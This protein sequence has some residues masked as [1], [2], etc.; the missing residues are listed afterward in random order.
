[1]NNKKINISAHL[2]NCAFHSLTP[3]ILKLLRTASNERSGFKFNEFQPNT[4]EAKRFK[5]TS[6]YQHFKKAFSEYFKLSKTDDVESKMQWLLGS[7]SHPLDVQVLLGPVLR[8]TLKSVLLESIA[9]RSM[10]KD[11]FWDLIQQCKERFENG[12]PESQRKNPMQIKQ[13]LINLDLGEENEFDE[14]Y[15]PNLDIITQ[16]LLSNRGAN[17]SNTLD[18]YGDKAYEQY[19]SH[20]CDVNKC[21]FVSKEQL[22]MLCHSFYF[23]LKVEGYQRFS[24]AS[25]LGFKP[26]ANVQLSNET[27]KHWEIVSKKDSEW[28]YEKTS[29][30]LPA[31][32][33][34]YHGQ[35]QHLLSSGATYRQVEIL[36]NTLRSEIHQSIADYKVFDQSVYTVLPSENWSNSGG[37]EDL[38]GLIKASM[39]GERPLPTAHKGGVETTFQSTQGFKDFLEHFRRYYS[40]EESLSHKQ[41]LEKAKWLLQSYPHPQEQFMI[42]TPVL[43]SLL[44]PTNLTPTA[45]DVQDTMRLCDIFNLELN[46]Y[47]S[48][49]DN[50]KISCFHKVFSHKTQ[51]VVF[52]TINIACVGQSFSPVR[53]NAIDGFKETAIYLGSKKHAFM[54]SANPER[55]LKDRLRTLQESLRTTCRT[56]MLHVESNTD[57]LAQI[58]APKTH[59]AEPIKKGATPVST[60]EA[61]LKGNDTQRLLEFIERHNINVNQPIPERQRCLDGWLKGEEGINWSPLHVAIYHGR[62]DNVKALIGLGADCRAKAQ[63]RFTS[64]RSKNAKLHNLSPLELAAYANRRDISALI[65]DS[66]KPGENDALVQSA[67]NGACAFGYADV[68][69]VFLQYPGI[70]HSTK[71]LEN[72]LS[73]Q[74]LFLFSTLLELG[75]PLPNKYQNSDNVLSESFDVIK[76]NASNNAIK[77]GIALHDLLM[78]TQHL[79]SKNNSNEITS[80][81][82]LTQK[83]SQLIDVAVKKG[84]SKWVKDIAQYQGEVGS[85]L[86][87]G[88]ASNKI[89]NENFEIILEVLAKN[90]CLAITNKDSNLLKHCLISE[91]RCLIFPGKLNPMHHALQKEKY[92]FLHDSYTQ[93]R[94]NHTVMEK[95]K[96]KEEIEARLKSLNEKSYDEY[97]R[98]FSFR[99][100]RS[101]Y[102]KEL[103]KKLAK[104]RWHQKPRLYGQ[105]AGFTLNEGRISIVDS[106]HLKGKHNA[107]V[108]NNPILKYG[109]PALQI[110]P[111]VGM[112]AAEGPMRFGME[113]SK[114]AAYRYLP[115][116]VE[117]ATAS[118]T[119]KQI[120]TAGTILSHGL[121]FALMPQYY[122]LSTIAGAGVYYGCKYSG[123]DRF[124]SL[125]A[126]TQLCADQVCYRYSLG[127]STEAV[128][129]DRYFMRLDRNLSA[130]FGAEA[131]QWLSPAV[132]GLDYANAQLNQIAAK[133]FEVLKPYF[134]ASTLET[135]QETLNLPEFKFDDL[136]F[137]EELKTTPEY[138]QTAQGYVKSLYQKRQMWE[139]WAFNYL[140][141]SI[142]EQMVDSTFKAERMHAIQAYRTNILAFDI[143]NTENSVK[144]INIKIEEASENLAQETAKLDKLKNDLES[145]GYSTEQ[146]L[147]IQ[148]QESK[149]LQAQITLDSLSG[150]LEASQN[151]LAEQELAFEEAKEKEESLFKETEGYSYFEDWQEKVLEAKQAEYDKN[152]TGEEKET[153]RQ[154]EQEALSKSRYYN[155]DVTNKEAELWA[156][157]VNVLFDEH[158]DNFLDTTNIPGTMQ[159]I[160][161][162]AFETMVG[163]DNDRNDMA[164]HFAEQI[165]RFKYPFYPEL[166]DIESIEAELD[167][168]AKTITNDWMDGYN[169]KGKS[170]TKCK[171]RV[172]DFITAEIL[173]IS[174]KELREQGVAY[175]FKDGKHSFWRHIQMTFANEIIGTLIGRAIYPYYKGNGTAPGRGKSGSWGIQYNNNLNGSYNFQVIVNHHPV[176]TIYD[177]EKQKQG[178]TLSLPKKVDA[179]AQQKN[180]LPAVAQSHAIDEEVPQLIASEQN[181]I[182]PGLS[183]ENPYIQ[184]A[185]AEQREIMFSTKPEAELA[186]GNSTS[187]DTSTNLLVTKQ[188]A[189]AKT[190][191]KFLTQASYAFRYLRG[192]RSPEILEWQ[193]KN[194]EA[195][196][197]AVL[198]A[199]EGVKDTK[200]KVD[201]IGSGLILAVK[202]IA[203]SIDTIFTLMNQNVE[204]AIPMS[205]SKVKTQV[206]RG[207]AVVPLAVAKSLYVLGTFI[208]EEAARA[209]LNE[210]LESSKFIRDSVNN[211]VINYD[212][213]NENEKLREISRL[214]FSFALPGV[215]FKVGAQATKAAGGI[216]RKAAVAVEKAPSKYGLRSSTLAQRPKA[217]P[218]EMISEPLIKKYSEFM[219]K[220]PEATRTL[221]ASTLAQ[222]N[223]KTSQPPTILRQFEQKS[224]IPKR[225][226]ITNIQPNTIYADYSKL[227]GIVSLEPVEIRFSQSSV[228]FSKQRLDP[229]TLEH[230]SYTYNDIVASMQES[231]WNGSPINV[232]KMPDGSLT[233]IDNTRLLAAREAGIKV[234]VN[235]HNF[236]DFIPDRL[237]KQYTTLADRPPRTWGEAIQDRINDQKHTYFQTRPF[238]EKFK[239]GSIY[240]PRLIEKKRKGNKK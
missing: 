79:Q 50:S 103:D 199:F 61:L 182:L 196:S 11:S 218:S 236:N 5:T 206:L 66:I 191:I 98:T 63:C 29:E 222:R 100:E 19:V 34:H 73:H 65:L 97:D 187:K 211:F 35:M 126:L 3:F 145:R 158:K 152:L 121:S 172:E 87:L 21:V 108:Y 68:L 49:K 136:P 20:Q 204:N 217:V 213:M 185:L 60:L 32:L 28:D 1:M 107:K 101:E 37:L 231:G 160:I 141:E 143:H 224:N 166:G 178:Y 146:N 170:L 209:V 83:S 110:L 175:A 195:T 55:R 51:D 138:V 72:A 190:N 86:Q 234:K 156:E 229:I 201:Y 16:V 228:S 6:G 132:Y 56:G 43:R 186:T 52:G 22:E 216:V 155:T 7:H 26:L 173:G 162:F 74:D 117:Y 38:V 157:A 85:L 200:T 210:E 161:N 149:V 237:A 39:M 165:I 219:V 9:H 82:N 177:S 47:S 104:A 23:N 33:A 208:G 8:M 230:K 15:Y 130:H 144:E 232:V 203:T 174:V 69:Y 80:G 167:A 41:I 140:E 114:I 90:A 225:I 133:P 53:K 179:S 62:I 54:K 238:S 13:W 10:I 183:Y 142:L 75:A 240:D 124:E 226:E 168:Y 129:D 77:Y 71:A 78:I 147:D 30:K 112:I 154:E 95:A 189:E 123:L 111:H 96:E 25:E 227:S 27:Q 48:Q 239:N 235:I 102:K 202:D 42:I 221:R 24:T 212:N 113:V 57:N 89:I 18:L 125:E 194:R 171:H 159:G 128:F 188:Q 106:F 67:Y 197:P 93:Y 233:T 36:Q 105:K 99:F 120:Q 92:R 214:V 164:R 169:K 44:S 14:L 193:R 88:S 2:N 220:P 184:A 134:S 150:S 70:K 151:I 205:D 64:R 45:L 192:D 58:A 148:S 223:P 84:L 180:V 12:V 135:I 76:N 176:V 91:E 31:R 40:L 115:A 17:K 94:L 207:A 139:E 116:L 4:A 122:V 163:P 59:Q 137:A 181:D 118:Y 81:L 131:T 198:A 153:L 127:K 46:V 109:S 119:P 215:T